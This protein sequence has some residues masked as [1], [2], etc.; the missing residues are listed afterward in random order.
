MNFKNFDY[1]QF[2]FDYGEKVGLAAAGFI[3]L[4]LGMWLFWPGNGLFA[5]SA[6]SRGEEL[7]GY[8]EKVKQA[9]SKNKPAPWS[10]EQKDTGESPPGDVKERLGA[11]AFDLMPSD[12][13]ERDFRVDGLFN[14]RQSGPVGRQM[15]VVLAPIESDSAL[16]RFQMPGL[17][18]SVVNDKEYLLTIK[19]PTGSSGPGGAGPMNPNSGGTGGGMM[20]PR[21]GPGNPNGGG[22]LQGSNYGK[23]KGL[24]RKREE[25]DADKADHDFDTAWKLVED[26]KEGTDNL[27]MLPV[28]VRGGEIVATFPYKAEVQEFMDRLGLNSL[29]D[30]LNNTETIKDEKGQDVVVHTF[31]FDGVAVERRE[32]D[33]QGRPVAATPDGGWQPLEATMTDAY[34]ANVIVS[35]GARNLQKETRYAKVAIPGLTLSKLPTVGGYEDLPPDLRRLV[36]EDLPNIEDNLK[37]LKAEVDDLNK[38]PSKNVAKPAFTQ[39][40]GNIWNLNGSNDQGGAGGTS[41][42]TMGP[43][44]KPSGPPS[45]STGGP[46]GNPNNPNGGAG[47]RGIPGGAGIPGNPMGGDNAKIQGDVPDYVL[48][49]LFDFTDMDPGKTYQY[50]IRVKM[51][52]PNYG[53]KDVASQGVAQGKELMEKPADKDWYVVPQLLTAAPDLYIYAVD[54]LKLDPK[55]PKEPRDKDAPPPPPKLTMPTIKS[56]GTQTALQIQ[57]WVPA[58]PG[59]N[60]S[61][62]NIGDWVIAERVPATRGEPI[63]GRERVEVPYWRYQQNRFMMATDQPPPKPPA[64]KHFVATEDVPF[65]ADDQEPILVDFRGGAVPYAR[66]HPKP[67]D[68]AAPPA[69]APIMDTAPE[70]IL[71]YTADGKLLARNGAKDM[72]DPD[73]IKRLKDVRDWIDAVKKAKG[74]KDD[75]M[76]NDP[77]KPGVPGM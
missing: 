60:R 29:E 53:R 68:G 45:G 40:P 2:F 30:V 72:E 58:L 38:D 56:D 75:K 43:G 31:R 64:D 8:T 52:N 16:V 12:Q 57:K 65:M 15:P 74:G 18:Y 13:I 41:G 62:L 9:L 6:A 34:K 76:F 28:P 19:L 49:R 77:N 5:T 50:R 27:A 70:E 33:A 44:G 3:A 14:P 36:H 61:Q 47:G 54:Q 71:L 73:R 55:E 4:L 17:M 51:A 67:D 11:F 21:G 39:D 42:G 46:G 25:T 1:K 66:T 7:N 48:I 23:R 69:E 63:A 35:G 20:G 10:P 22:Q 37:K 24:L 59:K 26:V 32:V